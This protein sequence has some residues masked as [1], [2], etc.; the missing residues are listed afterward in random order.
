MDDLVS[1]YLDVW[2]EKDPAA[3]QAAIKELFADDARYVDPLADVR[4]HES[5]DAMIGGAQAQF[6]DFVFRLKPGV[7]TH[8]DVGRFGWE[9]GPA[10]GDAVIVGIDVMV[11]DADGRIHDV[12][13]FWD[14]LPT[15]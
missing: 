14:Q 7:D 1:R 13:G 3:R 2:N 8:H 10:D 12:F 6:P 9:L 5:I 4:G 15:A 11:L